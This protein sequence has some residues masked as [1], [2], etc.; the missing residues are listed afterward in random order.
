[1]NASTS[2]QDNW[3]GEKT[4]SYVGAALTATTLVGPLYFMRQARKEN[5]K[6]RGSLSF[7]VAKIVKADH[8]LSAAQEQK[9][10]AE[11]TLKVLKRLC[12]GIEP[13]IDAVGK[14]IAFWSD[15]SLHIGDTAK[16][17]ESADSLIRP[18]GKVKVGTIGEC[19]DSWEHIQETYKV[20]VATVRI[21]FSLE[22]LYMVLNTF[23]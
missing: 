22:G 8:V 9:K 3:E 4:K 18:N 6:A 14:H 16:Q 21:P 1:M 11:E 10:V 23:V 7:D 13:A 2:Q 19:K 17:V 20:Y 12:R 15:I 5:K